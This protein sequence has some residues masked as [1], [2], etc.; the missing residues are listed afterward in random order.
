MTGNKVNPEIFVEHEGEK[1]YF[2]CSACPEKFKKDPAK[3]MA[4]LKTDQKTEAD[5]H[6]GHDHG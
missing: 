5:P 6:A 3:Y 4:A 2:C 1:V